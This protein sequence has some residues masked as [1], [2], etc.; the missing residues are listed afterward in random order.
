[1][2]VG[3]CSKSLEVL[4][5]AVGN[6]FGRKRRIRRL[7][8]PELTGVTTKATTF[9]FTSL[10]NSFITKTWH[11]NHPFH[12]SWH[13]LLPKAATSLTPLTLLLSRVL[14]ISFFFNKK[15][16]CYQL[17]L[18]HILSIPLS[19]TLLLEDSMFV[20]PFKLSIYREYY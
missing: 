9:C 6:A 20:L 8:V 18:I 15:N 16:L 12:C 17:N 11:S 4:M 10:F 2:C 1:M 3:M 5:M 7:K 14:P 19:W 13:S